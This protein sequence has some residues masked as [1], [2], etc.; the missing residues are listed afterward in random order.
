MINIRVGS[1]DVPT[2]GFAGGEIVMTADPPED[3][4]DTDVRRPVVRGR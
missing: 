3:I 2:L 4:A 1:H